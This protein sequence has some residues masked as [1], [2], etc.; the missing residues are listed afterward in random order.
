MPKPCECP[1]S[2]SNWQTY[3]ENT[4]GG[5]EP[6]PR[7]RKQTM[8]KS[9]K[10]SYQ[11]GRSKGQGLTEY[12]GMLAFVAILGAMAFSMVGKHA[13]AISD[14]GSACTQQ[15]NLAAAA[16]GNPYGGSSSDSGSSSSSS[17]DSGSSSSAGAGSSSSSSSSSNSGSGSSASSGSS[18]SSSSN[19][20]NGN[21]G[22]GNS[23][24][25]NG[26]SGNG[27]RGNNGN[28]WAYG[29]N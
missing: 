21:N 1:M 22:N 14:L 2:E 5:I 16:G 12:A 29:R 13:S 4:K 28:G 25:G 23:G 24:N 17:S 11:R 7:R 6:K 3:D 20:G 18:S 19:S 9:T 15:L 26:N 10:R 27:N 8:R